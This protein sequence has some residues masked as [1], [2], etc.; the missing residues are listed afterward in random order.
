MAIGAIGLGVGLAASGIGMIM[1]ARDRRRAQRALSAMGK[2]PE[3]TVPKE[4]LSAYQERLR[5]SK[6]YQGFSQAELNQMR[7]SQARQNATMFNRAAG[8][9]SSSMALQTIAANT[10][11]RNWANV[12][13]QNAAM[14]RQGRMANQSAADALADR[15]GGYRSMQERSAQSNY[16]AMQQAYGEAIRQSRQNDRDLIGQFG[17][18]GMTMATK[19]EF[20]G[21]GGGG[22]GVNLWGYGNAPEGTTAGIN[23]E[24]YATSNAPV[25]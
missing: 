19:P 12:A 3:L 2:R 5:Q 1:S 4:V 23:S 11:A 15:V 21:I 10:D 18:M 24:G 8:L 16:D 13:S 22:G 20:W 7:S 25:Q 17:T 9:G 14:D 6:M